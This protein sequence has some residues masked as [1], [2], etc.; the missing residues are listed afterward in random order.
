MRRD[1]ARQYEGRMH[2]THEMHNMHKM[3]AI[4]RRAEDDTDNANDAPPGAGLARVI[5]TL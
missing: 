2:T 3:H 1:T 4:G 5:C